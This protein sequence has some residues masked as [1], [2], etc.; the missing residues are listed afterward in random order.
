MV[1]PITCNKTTYE[2]THEAAPQPKL[3]FDLLVPPVPHSIFLTRAATPTHTGLP[4]G[5]VFCL[6]VEQFAARYLCFCVP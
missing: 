2:D 6:L 5:A 3:F 1:Q 4:M